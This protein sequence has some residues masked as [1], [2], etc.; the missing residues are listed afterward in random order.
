MVSELHLEWDIAFLEQYSK[1]RMVPRGLRWTIHPQQ[2]DPDTESWFHYF[3]EAGISLLGFLIDRKRTRR[4]I[5][6]KEIK[7]IREKLL[8][9]KSSMEYNN[10]STNLKNHLEKE[11]REQKTKKQKKYSRDLSDY[12]NGNVFSW[13]TNDQIKSTYDSEC[14]PMEVGG[15]SEPRP[16]LT[17]VP[18]PTSNSRNGTHIR[19]ANPP[20][21]Y[22]PL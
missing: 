6:D 19:L 21:P 9:H 12:K 3:N 17:P 13:Q 14:P 22:N 8:P 7:E 15:L 5:I 4:T 16:P 1:E 10:L 11:E 18:P 20:Y 2:G